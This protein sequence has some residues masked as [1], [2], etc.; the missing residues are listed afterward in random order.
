MMSSTMFS[1]SA[2]STSGSRLSSGPLVGHIIAP[3]SPSVTHPLLLPTLFL[4]ATN[5]ISV[6][7][8]LDDPGLTAG[9]YTG[10]V[11]DSNPPWMS[12]LSQYQP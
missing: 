11:T 4:P 9:P 7:D 8:V 6:V 3:R 5:N 1:A 12:P 10:V 2:T